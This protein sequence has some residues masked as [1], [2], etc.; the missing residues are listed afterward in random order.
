MKDA[1]LLTNASSSVFMSALLGIYLSSL[2]LFEQQRS[3]RFDSFGTR[4]MIEHDR[5]S[6]LKILLVTLRFIETRTIVQHVGDMRYLLLIAARDNVTSIGYIFVNAFAIRSR[7]NYNLMSKNRIQRKVNRAI[8]RITRYW[9]H[10]RFATVNQ[11]VG[12]CNGKRYR[13]CYTLLE[14]FSKS[15]RLKRTQ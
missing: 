9:N 10:R 15:D 5:W 6:E 4:W 11:A 12:E 1:T 13:I 2:L 8:C 14:M 7:K 3:L